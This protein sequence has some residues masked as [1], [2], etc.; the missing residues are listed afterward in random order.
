MPRVPIPLTPGIDSEVE[1][2]IIR[3]Y[4]AEC[5]SQEPGIVE[6]TRPP[7]KKR[8]EKRKWAQQTQYGIK[9][10]YYE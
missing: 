4:Q 6:P 7:L 5:R 2:V 9:L 3:R 10:R 1:M 8:A